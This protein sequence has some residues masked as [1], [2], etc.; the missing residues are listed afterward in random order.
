MPI[1]EPLPET[2]DVTKQLREKEF[3][4]KKKI[5]AVEPG[6]Y[7]IIAEV[8][9]PDER[10]ITSHGQIIDNSVRKEAWLWVGKEGMRV[11]DRFRDDVFPEGYHTIPGPLTPVGERPTIRYGDDNSIAETENRKSSE[12]V[13]FLY[14]YLNPETNTLTRLGGRSVYYEITDEY[15]DR[16]V[17]SGTKYTDENGEITFGCDNY[18]S[19]DTKME[20]DPD[21]GAVDVH[22]NYGGRISLPKDGPL[23]ACNYTFEARISEPYYVY[24]EMGDIVSKSKNLFS[25]HSRKTVRVN[26]DTDASGAFYKPSTDE[27]HLDTT[28]YDGSSR[29]TWVM[30]HEYGHALHE[31]GFGGN[32]AGGN[33]PNPHYLSGENNLQCAFSEGLAN[34]HAF[35]VGEGY[36]DFE[37]R[38]WTNGGSKDGAQVEGAVAS[39][40][41]DI[42]D[43][44]NE[45]IDNLSLTGEY[46]G[47]I[48]KTCTVDGGQR[49]DGVDHLIACMQQEIPS[50]QGYFPSRSTLPSNFSEGADEP[51]GWNAEDVRDLWKWNLYRE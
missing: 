17:R 36:Y 4:V 20:L 49:A 35:A 23:G 18:E 44:A 25:P 33:C 47:E 16:V 2:V 28:S 6:Y 7:M 11:T 27:I 12:R 9:A 43:P 32:N 48:I 3:S 21:G 38:D 10:R 15:E 14:T 13:T 8:R 29:D 34:Y 26:L 40:F 22:Y 39:F 1:G 19:V 46:V 50:Y 30:A 45:T 5:K 41:T 42:T 37:S 31:K 51:S 24:D